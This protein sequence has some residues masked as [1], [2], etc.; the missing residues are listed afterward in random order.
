MAN[1]NLTLEVGTNRKA[2]TDF[3]QMPKQ[4]S[5]NLEFGRNNTTL[6]KSGGTNR[7]VPIYICNFL[8]AK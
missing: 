1:M 4:S 2:T 8:I 3:F 7:I 5:G 6:F